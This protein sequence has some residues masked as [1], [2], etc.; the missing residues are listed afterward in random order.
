VGLLGGMIQECVAKFKQ[1]PKF[2]PRAQDVV[3]TALDQWESGL[4]R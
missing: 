3:Q 1:D 4:R 2:G